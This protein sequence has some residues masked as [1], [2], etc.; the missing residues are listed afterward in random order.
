LS[1][2][3]AR[4]GG[5]FATDALDREIARVRRQGAPLSVIMVD[6]DGLKQ[7][8]DRHGH[9]AGDRAIR[10]AAACLNGVLRGGD[11]AARVGGDEFV[12]VLP[13]C[14][15]EMLGVV[16]ERLQSAA[17]EAGV[18]PASCTVS[19][20]GAVLRDGDDADSLLHRADEAMYGAK[21]A[22]KD[23]SRIAA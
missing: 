5:R 3:C 12:A 9:G 6:L 21:R 10:Q 14:G 16:I 7:V 13:N 1:A 11:Y 18:S 23:Q 22:G 8:N 4:A 15:P 19:A 17:R 20:G 2:G